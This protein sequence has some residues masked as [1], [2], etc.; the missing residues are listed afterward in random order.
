MNCLMTA[1][2]QH[3]GE[4]SAW[5]RRR[6]GNAHDAEDLLEELSLKALRDDKK[7]CEIGNARTWPFEVA[8]AACAQTL[9]GALE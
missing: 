3:E 4:L 9:A 7:F 1:W 2:D 8:R 5:L 6:L